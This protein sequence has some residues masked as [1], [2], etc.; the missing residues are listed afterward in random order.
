MFKPRLELGIACSI[1]Y[2][3]IFLSIIIGLQRPVLFSESLAPLFDCLPI[4]W[5]KF[6]IAVFMLPDYGI[7]VLLL[8]VL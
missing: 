8:L 6:P 7:L 1:A 5:F 2:L 4:I 3:L